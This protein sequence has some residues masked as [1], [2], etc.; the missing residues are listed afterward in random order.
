MTTNKTIAEINDRF[1]QKG[2]GS[3]GQTVFTQQVAAMPS[4]DRAAIVLLVRLFNDFSEENDPLDEHNFGSV[5]H[6]SKTY[7]WRFE[8][9]D[10]NYECR[11]K[12]HSNLAITRRVLTIMHSSEYLNLINKSK[13]SADL[14]VSV[15]ILTQ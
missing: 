14:Y 1:R 9:W 6:K 10:K 13:Y 15:N 2:D 11:S 7:F 3:L 4:E 12:N 8:Y 5:D